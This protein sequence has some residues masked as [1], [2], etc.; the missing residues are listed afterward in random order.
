MTTMTGMTIA[1]AG[2]QL[3]LHPSGALLWPRRQMLVA[4]DL[5]LE[6]GSHWARR[7]YFL[8]PY[9]T[10]ATLARLLRTCEETQARRLLLLGDCFHDPGGHAR[11]DLGARAAFDALQRLEPI[12]IRGNHDGGFVPPGF[13]A[14]DTYEDEGLLF[15]HEAQPG[16]AHEISGHFHPKARI[17]HKG[18]SVERPC[19]VEDGRKLILPAFGAYT[20]GLSVENPAIRQLFTGAPRYHLLGRERVFSFRA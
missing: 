15:R 1:F 5:H 19:F 2:Q 18:G 4:S 3:L 17:A 16:A 9:D 8:P 10:H 12:W 20:G 6:K 7:G 14:H 11:L 13:E